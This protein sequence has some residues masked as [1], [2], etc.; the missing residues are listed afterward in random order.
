MTN[1]LANLIATYFGLG[2]SPKA[3]GTVGSLGTLPLAFA[4]LYCGGAKALLIA[5][6]IICIIGIWATDTIISKQEDKDPGQ[7]VV[8]E[9][10]GQLLTFSLLPSYLWQ[11]VTYMNLAVLFL[12]FGLFRLF[13][14]WKKGPV[15]WFDTKMKNA[16]GVMFDDVCAGFLAA[17]CLA[18]VYYFGLAR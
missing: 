13:D 3:P 7:V 5:A 18:L 11:D 15:K 1:R 17:I 9:V 16:C 10:V 8:D 4:L 14:I 12:G 6:W 2:L